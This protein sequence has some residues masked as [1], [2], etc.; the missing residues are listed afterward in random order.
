VRWG[1][2]LDGGSQ[3]ASPGGVPIIWN[4]L[5]GFVDVHQDHQVGNVQPLSTFFGQVSA[6]TLPAVSWISPN[7]RTGHPRRG[8]PSGH[9]SVTAG[10]QTEH[11]C[12]SKNEQ[13]RDIQG[14]GYGQGQG[15]GPPA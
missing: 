2:Y 6:G 13:H 3:P 10:K 7:H 15:S 5:P 14:G 9:A 12:V 1:Y 8:A 11:N 4:P